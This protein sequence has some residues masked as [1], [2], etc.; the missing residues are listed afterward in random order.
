LKKLQE[1]ARKSAMEFESTVRSEV[2][3]IEGGV[4]SSL[5]SAS[6]AVAELENSIRSPD[7]PAAPDLGPA[8]LDTHAE[9]EPRQLPGGEESVPASGKAKS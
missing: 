7:A 3:G 4:S 6:S 8:A 2:A 1:E 9:A 5:Q